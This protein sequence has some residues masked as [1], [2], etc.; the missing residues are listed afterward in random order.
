MKKSMVSN[1]FNFPVHEEKKGDVKVSYSQYT[2]WAN[3]PKQWK[4]TY[5]DGHRDF[6]PS[7]HLVFGTAMHETLQAWLQVMYNQSAVEAEKMDLNQLLLDEMAKEYKKMMAVYGVKFT[8]RSEMNEFYDDGVQIIDFLKKNRSDYFSTRKMRLVGVELP[9]YFPASEVNENVMMKGFLDLVFE[10]IDDG[11]IEIW[12]IKTSTKGW[13]KWQKA[14]KTKTAQL[15]LYKKFF[16]EQYGYPVDKIQVRYFIVKRKLWEEAMFAQ[17]RVQEFVPAHGKPTLNKIVNSFNDFIDVAFNDDG[18]Y[19][20]EGEFLPI[21]GKNNKNCKW[22]PFKT[23]DG[24]C[25]KK[26]RIKV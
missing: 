15:V 7:I 16:A 23:N 24:L 25:S 21:A 8:N 3:C 6:D 2:M 20:S 18:T 12:D 13:N 14:D 5:M 11:S 4:L 1:I 22:C 19:N 10:V 17:K 26:E 9:I